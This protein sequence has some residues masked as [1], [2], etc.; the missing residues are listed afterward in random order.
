V[1]ASANWDPNRMPLVGLPVPATEIKVAPVQGKLEFRLRGP[2]VTPGYWKNPELTKAAFDEDGFY[3]TG[4][5]VQF[6]D[7]EVPEKGLRFDGR[8]AENFKITNGTWVHVAELRE[9]AITAFAPL[10]LD[11]VI[12]APDRDYLG[13]VLFP[14][15]EACR[16]LSGLGPEA[17]HAEILTSPA[18]REKIQ[19]GLDAL[20]R[21][22]TGGANR[23]LR[24]CLTEEAA[25]LDTGELTDKRTIS[26]RAVLQ[27]R[28]NV[29]K[30]IYEEPPE[31]GV[32]VAQI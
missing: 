9:R 26:Q 25:T 10:I 24:A 3:K 30:A 6:I 13:A 4:D 28:L 18:V 27:R 15:M 23:I 12:T 2:C 31:P 19:S 7:P 1:P 29:V 5:A 21:S 11:A 17:S 16:T 20:A 14:N 22:A 32:F 8:I